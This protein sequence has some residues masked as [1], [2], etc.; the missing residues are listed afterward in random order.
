[1]HLEPKPIAILAEFDGFRWLASCDLD[2]EVHMTGR[3]CAEAIGKLAI[4]F[5]DRFPLKLFA[6]GLRAVKTVPTAVPATPRE[7]EFMRDSIR[8][9]HCGSSKPDALR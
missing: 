7:V 5:K 8:D 6:Y 1:M 9:G 2:S 3:T 4:H